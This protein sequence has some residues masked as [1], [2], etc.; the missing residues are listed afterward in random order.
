VV[1]L[2]EGRLLAAWFAGTREGHRDVAIWLA[3]YDGREWGEPFVVAD[4]PDAPL[5]NPVLFRDGTDTVWLFYKAGPSV[6]AWTG[7]CRQSL[8]GGRA[9]SAPAALPIGIL[10][11]A[12][13][14]PLL[15]SNGDLL[16]GSSSETW[17]SWACWVEISGDDG[18]TWSKHGPI[19]APGHSSAHRVG[20][21]DP[22][23]AVWDTQAQAIVLPQQHCGIIQPTVWE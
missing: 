15:L 20:G 5:W 12:K 8:D 18:K 7:L 16:C 21:D 22:T 13:N 11:P 9:W 19:V 14:K 6:P 17:R 10:G 23:S 3:H 1:E 2:A 4:E